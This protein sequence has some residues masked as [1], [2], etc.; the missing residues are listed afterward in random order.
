MASSTALIARRSI[1]ARLGRLIAIAVAIVVGVS[2][3]VGSFVLADSLRAGFDS[4]FEQVSQNVDFEVRSS[5]A[6]DDSG[7]GG[8]I[9]RDPIPQDVADQVAAV[10][11]VAATEP[12]IQRYAQFV[13]ADG[14]AVS[15]G[16]APTF[17]TAWT[18][19]AS[20]SGIE[21]KGEGQPPSGP[22]QIAVDKATA[23]REDFEV[24][25]QV[26][27]LTDTGS[28][29]FTITALVGVGDSD[30]F[31]GATMAVWD[32]PTAQSV[33]GAEGVFDALDVGVVDGADAATVRQ[34]IADVLPDGTE[35]VDRATLI[36]EANDQVNSFIGPF[37]TGLLIFA[38]ITAFVSAFLINNVFAITIGQRLRELALLRA[39]GASGRQVRRMIFLEALIMSVIATIVGIGGGLLV[40]KGILAVFN[41]AGAGFPDT[42]LKLLPRT[43]IWAFIV[44]VGVTMAAVIIPALRAARIPPVAAMRPELGF[45]VLSAR[46]LVGGTIVTVLGAGMFL[47]GIFA[48]PGGTLG[49]VALA[50]G[51]GVLI[52]LGVASLSSTVARPV[53]RMI[54]WPVAKVY[55][56]PGKL[57]R[58]N[59]G[60]APRRTSATA[61]ALMI[62]VALVSAAA[63]FAASLRATFVGVLERGVTADL[64]VL[65]ANQAGGQGLPPVVAETIKALPEV[66]ASTPIRGVPAQVE[67]EL[68]FL[69]AADPTAMPELI[70]IDITE[71]GYD[72]LDDGG[73]LV[74]KDP[75]KDLDLQLGDTVPV[76][77]Q[78]GQ[79]RDL[80]VVGIY[81]DAS[82][83][84]NWL[85]SLSTLDDVSTGPTSDFFIPIKLAEGVDAQAG[86]QAVED[87]LTPYPQA[88]V[89]SNAEFREQLEA[90]IDQ[91]LIVITV[92]LAFAIAIAVLGISITL[93]L[94]VFERTREIG[95]MRAVG[96]TKRQTRRTV[97]WEAVIVS[98]FGAIVGIVV[99]TLI[100]I[101]LSL[102]VPNTVVDGIAF[103]VPT[104]VFILIGA[105]VAGLI[106]ALYP[107][108]KASNMDVLRAIATE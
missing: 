18:G 95:L 25:D 51:G 32:V 19:D 50:G 13:D 37:G 100:G 6:F 17:G 12:L 56:T 10:D 33:L 38:F 78:N 88:E 24:G 8:Q 93:A 74:H 68:K 105:V 61:S 84:G 3:V 29:Q 41:A 101:A 14:D 57:A 53:T 92:L 26:T 81:N 35:I 40:A 90:Q 71:G 76:T 66:G 31:Y 4:L 87:A 23:D 20:L 15:T 79:D 106:A 43:I 34:R 70:N 44:G 77:F 28:H 99:G 16:G 72:G 104:I 9:Q 80:T 59:A 98:T 7:Q 30:G 63:V 75:A 27:V 97:R 58:E 82:L 46:R 55:G 107:S 52:F 89:Q 5:V 21:I 102:A 94:G 86:R 45:D 2:F 49:T 103:S 67:G 65:P 64:L 48:R 83:A 36:D 69:G 22:D 108:Y 85:V 42:A 73:I 11:G 62:G 1:R 47:L 54:G 96:M 60:R 39:V 91:L